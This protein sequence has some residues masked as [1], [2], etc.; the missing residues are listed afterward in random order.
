MSPLARGIRFCIATA[1]LAITSICAAF[2]Q[3]MEEVDYLLID[4]PVRPANGKIEVIEFFHYG[5]SACYR[6]EPLLA[7]WIARL[8]EDVVFRRIPALRRQ[9]WIP[10]TRLY[11]A[12]GALGELGRLHGQVYRDV[13]E[14]RLNLGNSSEALPW[15]E[16]QGLDR[17]RFEAALASEEVGRE[18][19]RAR[20]LTVT[21]GVRSTPTMTVDGRFLTH[22]ALLGDIN[23]LLP[24]TDTLIDKART[25]R[26]SVKGP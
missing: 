9:D 26:K 20:D 1:A 17:D 6:F 5:C 8:P 22:A 16:R 18:V 21:Y 10:L 19:Q 15:A 14:G 23:A 4:P 7:A 25:A 2:A 24:M 13:H 12:L 3:P 11:F